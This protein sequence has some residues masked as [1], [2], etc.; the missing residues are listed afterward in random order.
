MAVTTQL[1]LAKTWQFSVN[2]DVFWQA[3]NAAFYRAIIRKI[4]VSMMGV[5]T[6]PWSCW[7]SCDSTAVATGSSNWDADTDLVWGATNAV[8]AHSWIVLAQAGLG[9]AQVLISLLG[10]G[11]PTTIGRIAVSPGGLYTGGTTTT[12]P[13]A[14][15]EIVLV[16]AGGQ[17]IA[18]STASYFLRS[19]VHYAQS[20]DGQCSRLWISAFQ[21]IATTVL[22]FD[23]LFDGPYDQPNPLFFYALSQ[24]TA[25]LASTN[26]QSVGGKSRI[27]SIEATVFMTTEGARDAYL[28]SNGAPAMGAYHH[29]YSKRWPVMGVGSMVYTRGAAG[30]AGVFYDLWLTSSLLHCG[31]T[32]GSQ[33]KGVVVGGGIAFPW[34]GTANPKL[35]A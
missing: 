21:G 6:S 28:L 25:C 27:N 1:R 20:A 12:D 9:G 22:I 29:D 17:I 24:D 11:S 31:A 30:R 7:K 23:K 18:P 26:F 34:D 33:R 13:T 3:S 8:N 14:T 10:A 5:A 15:D 35:G 19:V 16:A 2:Q 4:P 32:L